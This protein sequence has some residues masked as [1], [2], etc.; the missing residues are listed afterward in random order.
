M[1]Q[2][3]PIITPRIFI[4]IIKNRTPNINVMIGKDVVIIVASI[5][6]VRDLFP[7]FPIIANAFNLS[8]IKWL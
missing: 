7:L 1:R 2:L 4:G 5:G 8:T 6:D 3:A